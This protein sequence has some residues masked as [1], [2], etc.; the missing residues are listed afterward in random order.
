MLQPEDD[1]IHTVGPEPW[2]REAWYWGFYDRPSDLQFVCYLGV[3]PNQER[4]DVIV[5]IYQHQRVLHH[6]MKMDYHIPQDIGEDRLSFGPVLMKIVEPMKH[7]EVCYTSPDVQVNVAF[8]ALHEAYSWAE[9]K[10]WM[11]AEKRG[12]SSN[13][14][15]Q[16]GRF[17][18]EVR[19]AGITTRIDSLGYRDR[20]W[21]WGGRSKW[22]QYVML[23]PLFDENFTVNVYPQGFTDG[24]EQ[25]CGYILR[26]GERDLLKT[27]R[28]EIQWPESGR[29]ATHLTALVES[30][31]GEKLKVE[32]EPLNMV[33]T[34]G[35]WPHRI[36]HLLFG[37]ARY[38]CE[39]RTAFGDFAYYYQAEALRPTNWNCAAAG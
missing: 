35:W 37:T 8:R 10:L 26:N 2:W 21:G 13:H 15:D 4:A 12:A 20:M 38:Q 7:W 31:R 17:R 16:I 36:G 14:F 32:V 19:H 28:M 23:W 6:H 3:F 9:S 22:K 18:G 33:D 27:S 25:L 1:R 34:S 39:D 29:I 11:E 30:R 24:R 5:G